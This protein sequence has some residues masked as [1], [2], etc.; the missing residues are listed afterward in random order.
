MTIQCPHCGARGQLDDSKRPVGVT[1]IKCPRC[2]QSFPLPPLVSVQTPPAEPPP[3][4]RCPAC[5]GIIEGSGGLCNAC[6]A[7]RTRQDTTTA[8]PLPVV[9]PADGTLTGTC[10]VCKGR[11]AQ[12]EMVRF[13]TTQVCSACKPTYVQMLAMGLGRTGELRY[14]GFWIRFGAKFID[15]II[16]GLV[17]FV[18]SMASTLLV[19]SQKSPQAAITVLVLNMIINV[20]IAVAYNAWFLTS[21]YQATP[22]KIACGLKVVTADGVRISGLRAIGR[23]FAEMLSSLIMGIGYIMVAF[24]DEKRALHDRIC[25]TRVIYK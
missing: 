10:E 19:G 15:G 18:T 16:L 23:Y 8:T 12:S 2:N 22:G 17:N 13:G 1:S 7:A 6:D 4:R 5:G 9:A 14:A 21:K 25:N 24:D 20:A 11:F 3:L